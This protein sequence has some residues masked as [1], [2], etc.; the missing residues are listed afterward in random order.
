[1]YKLSLLPRTADDHHRTVDLISY[2]VAS[3]KPV[4]KIFEASL[5]SGRLCGSVFLNRIF[6]HWL[7][8]KFEGYLY[9][10]EDYHAEAMKRW[11][12]DLKKNFM[13]DVSKSH[14]IPVRGLPDNDR[15]NIRRGRLTITGAEMRDVIFE[16]VMREIVQLVGNQ[17]AEIRAQNKDVKKVLLAGGFGSN[18][19][20]KKRVQ[21]AVG[22][23]IE[24]VKV[25]NWYEL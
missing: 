16:P 12:S 4:P 23:A 9:W 7:R 15:L 20:L 18:A 10:D 8:R 11:D 21:D 5:G 25:E 17:I 24:V 2:T 19:Y 14:D 13:G 3:L 6:D 22:P 1:M